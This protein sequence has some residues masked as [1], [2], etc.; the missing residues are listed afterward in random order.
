MSLVVSE[1]LRSIPG[2]LENL[3]LALKNFQLDPLKLLLEELLLGASCYDLPRESSYHC[4]IYT[5]LR[6]L[7]L[8][9]EQIAQVSSNK[10]SGEGRYDIAV[11]FPAL[12]RSI[13]FEFKKSDSETDMKSDSIAGLAQIKDNDYASSFPGCTCF[14]V[15]MA[16]YKKNVSAFETEKIIAPSVIERLGAEMNLAR[17]STRNLKK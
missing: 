15:A 4:I 10:E 9:D 11:Y 16:F 8:G 5:I 13:I 2:Y 1:N 12:M 7:F 6:L 17:R 14:L 3:T